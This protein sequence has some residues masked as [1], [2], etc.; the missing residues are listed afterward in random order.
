MSVPDSDG[1]V[2]TLEYL[3]DGA[4]ERR[5]LRKRLAHAKANGLSFTLIDVE[6]LEQ[7][8]WRLDRP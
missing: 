3:L 8:I 4:R 2:W 7:I 1:K 5:G 6:S